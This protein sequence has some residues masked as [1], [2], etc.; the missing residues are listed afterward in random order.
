MHLL[1]SFYSRVKFL[2]VRFL[3][4]KLETPAQSLCCF[5]F[6]L[7][8]HFLLESQARGR[9]VSWYVVFVIEKVNLGEKIYVILAIKEGIRFTNKLSS[10]LTTF[11]R[12]EVF[13]IARKF[14]TL[15]D[16]SKIH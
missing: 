10:P 9:V 7:S 1:L 13:L 3:Y 6:C 11:I 12:K 14:V 2:H 15:N 16:C 8:V 4:V 5:V